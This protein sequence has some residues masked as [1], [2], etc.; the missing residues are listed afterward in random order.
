MASGDVCG[1][2]ALVRWPH[3]VHGLIPPDQFIPLAEQTG[4]IV[5][6]TDWVLAE[7]IR[8]CREWQRVGRRLDV[9]VNLSMWNLHDPALPDRVAELLRANSLSP[10]WLRLELTESALMADTERAMDVLAR[11]SA[12]GLRLA[13][14]DFGKG[15]SSLTYLKRLPVDELKIDKSFVREMAADSTDA[16]IV[17]ATVAMGH[18]LGLRVVAEGIEDQATWDML[19][20]MGCDVAQG[21][22]I[23]RPLAA[24]AL[25]RWLRE[26]PW[27]V[28]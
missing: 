27:A 8:Q 4:L 20:G 23:A 9:S 26:T 6:L 18:A 16:A 22:H 24:D 14:D 25:V 15:Y 13:V 2:E 12:L 21:Y 5:K 11:L 10:E 28:A 1:A 7:A 19:I 17:A 3:P